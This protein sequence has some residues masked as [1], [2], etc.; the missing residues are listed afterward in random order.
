MGLLDEEEDYNKYREIGFDNYDRRLGHL[1]S[2]FSNVRDDL[3]VLKVEFK[4][5]LSDLRSETRAG[6]A[7]V[8]ATLKY[9]SKEVGML[10]NK[11]PTNIIGWIG[12]AVIIVLLMGSV[13]ALVTNNISAQSVGMSEIQDRRLE[14]IEGSIVSY[15]DKMIDRAHFQGRQEERNADFEKQL[16]HLDFQHHATR[17]ELK[18]LAEDSAAGEVS[19]RAIGDYAKETRNLVEKFRQEK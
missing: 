11:P 18:R 9:F 16:E 8:V 15:Y 19:R 5:E 7:E 13:G 12:T 2:E 6:Q 1:E 14:A 17:D 4:S 10:T 3:N